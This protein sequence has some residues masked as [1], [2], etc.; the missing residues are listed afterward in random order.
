MSEK[1]LT[2]LG[3]DISPYSTGWAVGTVDHPAK[4]FGRWQPRG[5]WDWKLNGKR[6][7]EW[8]QFLLLKI[9][10][11]DVTYI[12]C[13]AFII[14][15]KAFTHDSH[16]PMCKQHGMV[17]Y[18]AE[19]AGIRAGAVSSAAWRAWFLGT[20][21]APS[22]KAREPKQTSRQW[23]KDEAKRLAAER[24]WYTDNDDTAE[25]LGIMDFALA[26]LDEDYKQKVGPIARRNDLKATTA[27]FRG[28]A[29]R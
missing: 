6:L 7:I 1:R 16:T 22:E 19:K 8:E 4:E 21:T 5:K 18:V 26:S 12:A 2:V 29:P 20:A 3:L 9:R 13:E 28:E 27:A 15:P 23:F 17:E 24:N 11:H 14:N 25:A 10:Q